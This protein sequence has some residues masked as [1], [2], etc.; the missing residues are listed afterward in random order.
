MSRPTVPS[1]Y[2]WSSSHCSPRPP[3]AAAASCARSPLSS[4][5]RISIAVAG[6]SRA[7]A[8]AARS[9]GSACNCSA[10]CSDGRYERRVANEWVAASASKKSGG[11]VPGS[12]MER[13]PSSRARGLDGRWW[14]RLTQR[15]DARRSCYTARV[16]DEE[17]WGKRTPSQEERR[18]LEGPALAARRAPAALRILLEFMRGFRALHFVGPCVTVFGSARFPPGHRYYELAREMGQ[19][20]AGEPA[21]R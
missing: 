10:A 5:Q 13:F 3:G 2:W 11:S 6:V 12:V 15:L 14:T 17:R 8:P 19:R 1:S 21:S 18:F 9:I 7:S 20:L 4:S 16:H